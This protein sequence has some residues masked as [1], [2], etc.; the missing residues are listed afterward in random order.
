MR[1]LVERSIERSIMS[2]IIMASMTLD[3]DCHYI[4]RLE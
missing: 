2:P 4:K 3:D 1:S